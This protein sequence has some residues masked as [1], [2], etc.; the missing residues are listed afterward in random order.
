MNRQTIIDALNGQSKFAHEVVGIIKGVTNP[1]IDEAY[2]SALKQ[3]VSLAKS[4]NFKTTAGTT[5]GISSEPELCAMAGLEI[6]DTGHT[7]PH[8][9]LKDTILQ[10]LKAK[11][12]LAGLSYLISTLPAEMQFEFTHSTWFSSE[13]PEIVG[14]VQALNDDVSEILGYDPL[15]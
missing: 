15:A 1:P 11:G 10:R 6:E 12:K 7:T 5:I 14:A 3:V 9:V 4:C 8:R 13:S 2:I